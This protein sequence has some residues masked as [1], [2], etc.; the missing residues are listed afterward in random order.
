[1][2]TK[3]L[4]FTLFCFLLF[5]CSPLQRVNRLVEKYNLS[6]KD[7][8]KVKTEILSGGKTYNFE[9]KNID[10]QYVFY[11]E[12]IHIVDG[13]TVRDTLIFTNY[14]TNDRILT[15]IEQKQDTVYSEK[16]VIVNKIKELKNKDITKDRIFF[17]VLIVFVI[18]YPILIWYL[19]RKK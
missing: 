19:G 9:Q 12:F 10:T 13:D 5:S 17:V 3:V 8:I 7:T 14:I 15:T 11:P 6:V 16:K 1:M 2:K 18:L 4:L